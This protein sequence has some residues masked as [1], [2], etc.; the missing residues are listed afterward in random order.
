MSTKIERKEM[1]EKYVTKFNLKKEMTGTGHSDF[2]SCDYLS[3]KDR[4]VMT[5]NQ[6][7]TNRRGFCCSSRY[8]Y[9]EDDTANKDF[10]YQLSKIPS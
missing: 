9:I 6:Y 3:Y 1:L 4:Y 10:L 8:D 2:N 5:I 7:E